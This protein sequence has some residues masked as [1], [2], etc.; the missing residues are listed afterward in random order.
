MILSPSM[1]AGA[2][3]D[4]TFG[5]PHSSPATRELSPHRDARRERL[6]S[7][8]EVSQGTR[9]TRLYRLLALTDRM[10]SRYGESAPWQVALAHEP[11]T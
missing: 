4:R 2:F 9:R 5:L 1:C 7:A 8:L 11:R 3:C 10:W 6:C